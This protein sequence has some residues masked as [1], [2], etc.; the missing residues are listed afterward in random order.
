ME[1]STTLQSAHEYALSDDLARL[2][3]PQEYKD[4]NRKLAWVNSVCCLFLLIGISGLKP[5][6]IVVKP[7]S[8]QVDIVP[9]VFTPPDEPPPAQEQ[10]QTDEPPPNSDALVDTP[11]VATVVAADA[12]QVAFAVPVIGPVTTM[13]ARFAPPPPA[14]LPKA[15]PKPTTFVPGQGGEGGTFPWPGGRDYP[16]EA[17]EQ[18]AQGKVML[19]V[20][21]DPSGVPST[22]EVKDGS[23][24]Y[25]LDRASVQWVKNKW[26]WLPGETRLFYVPFVWQLQ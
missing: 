16:R 18:R 24:Y 13:P 21:V 7:L 17:L 14:Q 25:S 6:K 3:L 8:E 20:V 26:R 4:S 15:P 1:A 5:P 12:S 2:C 23:G 19:Y 22:V 11:V 9:V 10:P